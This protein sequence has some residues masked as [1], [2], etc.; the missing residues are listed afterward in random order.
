MGN[1]LKWF[2]KN[3]YVLIFSLL[4]LLTYIVLFVSRSLDD[5]R[6][7][8]WQWAFTDINAARIFSILIPGLISA[9]IFSR[10]KLI[11]RYLAESS[12]R[13][14]VC[15][16][17]SSYII[18][19]LFWREPEVIIDASRY[20]TQAK[21]L[22]IY[23]I[24]YFFREWG[25][26]IMAWTD[27][28]L[29]PFLYGLIFKFFGESRLYIQIFTTF[30]F[31][32][33]VVLTYMI[34]KTLWD[35]DTGLYGGMLLLGIPY[36]F[37]QV[38]LMLVDVPTMFFLTLAIFTF[39]MALKRGG[40]W[41]PFSSLAIF[42][43]FYSKY[44]A[45]PML[46]V[47]VVI[48]LVYLLSQSS[49][50]SALSCQ[51]QKIRNYFYRGSVT[52]LIT[53]VLI[54]IVFLYKHEVFLEQIRLLMS[55]QKPGL[56]RWGESFI[57]TFFFQIH[58]FITAAALYSAYAA[59]RKKDLRYLIILWLVL[60]IVLF[61]IKRIR[62]I[63]MVFPMLSLMASYGLVQIERKEAARFI[64]LCIVISS[65]VVGLFGYLPFMQKI[66]AV[67]LKDAGRFL[68]SIEES[69]IEVFTLSLADPV[70]NPSVSVP[71]L[72]YFTKKNIIY[73]YE[74]ISYQ[75]FEKVE[76]SSLRFTWGYKNP[77]YYTGNKYSKENTAVVVI[78]DDTNDAL[79][80]KIE[81]QLSGYHL[82]IAFNRFEGIFRY[83]TSVRIYQP[84]R[85]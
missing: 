67:N 29:V 44:S 31:S 14:A 23:G 34:G 16:F 45:W 54:G 47:L 2:K 28:P 13:P 81:R 72:D 79:P 66:N 49:Q 83:R 65:V 38:P 48:F 40:S 56:K 36:L 22:E 62:Y 42:L 10:V 63:I 64:S 80:E 20:F 84:G 8:S 5:N 46:S 78:S 59:L 30:L 57:S 9:Y 43:A 82:S 69:N 58:P 85:D 37:V 35:E 12:L 74:N 6:L 11:E 24:G 25:R 3:D 1:I 33:T 73:D 77:E 75:P 19:A 50:L 52:F 76:K 41:I 70:S 7:T 27:M 55:Y 17:V 68:D 26:D 32:M 51:P 18:A 39:I 60:L 61:Q 15:L 71:V 21:H 53:A 4:A